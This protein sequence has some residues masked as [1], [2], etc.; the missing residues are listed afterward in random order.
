MDEA[1]AM[2]EVRR[3]DRVEVQLPGYTTCY[4]TIEQAKALRH[5]VNQAI[6]ETLP[7][8]KLPEDALVVIEDGVE[9]V[10]FTKWADVLSKVK[11]AR[12]TDRER[13]TVLL[14]VS[15][16]QKTDGIEPSEL[17]GYPFNS[18]SGTEWAYVWVTMDELKRAH[19]EGQ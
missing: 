11:D 15:D 7:P 5:G 18:A 8:P 4:L 13:G 2:P 9:W 10:R 19:N 6:L 14:L 17:T 16:A 1:I 12:V 3:F